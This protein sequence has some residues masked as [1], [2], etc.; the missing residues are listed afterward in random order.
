MIFEEE[1][2]LDY[3]EYQS[4]ACLQDVPGGVALPGLI[5]LK[6]L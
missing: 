5:L 6:K 3:D 4:E 2:C 1:V